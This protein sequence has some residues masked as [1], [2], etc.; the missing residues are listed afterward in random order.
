MLVRYK[1]KEN[2]KKLFLVLCLVCVLFSCTRTNY[3]YTDLD[4]S[5]LEVIKRETKK[6]SIIISVI[7]ID[8]KIEILSKIESLDVKLA[9]DSLSL[10]INDSIS[11]FYKKEILLSNGNE[12]TFRNF[13]ELEKYKDNKI[14][15]EK[16]VRFYVSNISFEKNEN[17]KLSFL[18][19][20]NDPLNSERFEFFMK[21][22]S[23]YR[24]VY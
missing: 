8:D 12:V 11:N 2:V 5:K 1:R 23:R 13:C 18:I 15:R 14:S 21:K 9:I 22:R 20:S 6:Y 16:I 4:D 19:N 3:Y 7:G 10:K 24:L 17:I